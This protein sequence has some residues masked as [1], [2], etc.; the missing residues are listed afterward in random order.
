MTPL[1]GIK[2]L[3]VTHQIAGPWTTRLLADLGVE[4][5]KIENPTG[6]DTSRHYPFFGSAVFAT[7]NRGKKSVTLNLKSK[8]GKE[9]ATRLAQRSDIFVE[10]FT[11]KLLDKLGLGYDNLKKVNPR[12]VYCSIS[13]YGKSSSNSDRPA[14]DAAVQAMSGLMTLTGEPDRPPMRVGTSIVDLTAANYALSGILLA[15]L[16]REKTGE[17]RFV[18]ISLFDAAISIVNYW[19][20]YS[21]ITGKTPMRMGNEWPALAPYQVFKAKN[22]EYVFIG[23]SND[24]FWREMCLILK[25]E[26]LIK[27][28]RFSTNERRVHNMKELAAIVDHATCSR[29]RDELVEKLVARGIPCAPVNTV[30]ELLSD[31]SLVKRGIL[32]E[33][34]YE[35]FESFLVAGNPLGALEPPSTG[36]ASPPKL[37]QHTD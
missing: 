25:L 5:I 10:N 20:A 24:E 9:I 17:G 31:P 3:D 12:L 16:E 4:V 8:A 36:I 14:W 21:S 23:A 26:D 7:E 19:I 6:G 37:G 29:D 30:R 13:G 22:D 1:S 15:L 2:C 35:T 33:T 34:N 18:D 27:D 28:E 11:P 32:V